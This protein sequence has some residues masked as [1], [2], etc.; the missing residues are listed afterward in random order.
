ML[1]LATVLEMM[2]ETESPKNAQAQKALGNRRNP[3]MEHPAWK[4]SMF[5]PGQSGNPSGRPK[6]DLA[7]EIARAVFEGDA[8][9]IR[10]SMQAALRKGNPKAYAVLADRGFGRL[11]Q[12]I[13]LEADLYHN[14]SDRQLEERLRALEAREAAREKLLTDGNGN[15]DSTGD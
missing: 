3:G 10:K 4:A 5:K 6:R 9:G 2:E 15:G 14:M 13:T 1:Q 11:P 7:A 8:E 12:P